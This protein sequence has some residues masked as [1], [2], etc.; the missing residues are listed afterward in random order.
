MNSLHWFLRQYD[1][2]SDATQTYALTSLLQSNSLHMNAN[3]AAFCVG[4]NA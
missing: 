1:E 3:I 2:K 4:F